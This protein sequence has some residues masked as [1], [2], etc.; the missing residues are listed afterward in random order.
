MEFTHKRE[1]DLKY[2]KTGNK[3]RQRE[4]ENGSFLR[5]GTYLFA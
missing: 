2:L 3:E 1:K 4:N 5:P